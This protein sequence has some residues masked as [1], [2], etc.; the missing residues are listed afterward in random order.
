MHSAV[1]NHIY[2]RNLNRNPPRLD[3]WVRWHSFGTGKS[4]T[5][6]SYALIVVPEPGK[7]GVSQSLYHI[8]FIYRLNC[9]ISLHNVLT[10]PLHQ[11][12]ASLKTS[13][14]SLIASISTAAKSTCIGFEKMSRW[15]N[16]HLM[17]LPSNKLSHIY[18]LVRTEGNPTSNQFKAC[19][20]EINSSTELFL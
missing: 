17:F 7:V 20:H 4:R 15:V 10:L 13:M 14:F 2:H 1:H 9:S 8:Y 12:V 6:H 5:H 16:F 19:P 11:M 3:T 18:L